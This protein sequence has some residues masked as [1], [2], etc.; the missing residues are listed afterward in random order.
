VLENFN[1]RA[2]L[3]MRREIAA[4]G[5]DIVLTISVENINVATWVAAWTLG[6]P[7]VHVIHSYFLMCW[8]STMF[9][10]NKTCERPCLQCRVASMGKKI[11]SHLVDGVAAEAAHSLSVH[12]EQGLFTRAAARVIPGAVKAPVSPPSFRDAQTGPLR[13]GYIGMLTPNKGVHTLAA[14]ATM[15]GN[16]APFEYLIAG[17]GKP[18]FVQEVLA[19]FPASKTS[20]FGWV[21]ANAFYPSID[22][23]VVPSVSA[24]CFGNVCVEALSFGVPVVV[25]RSGALPELVEHEKSGLIFKAGDHA[26]LADCL[27][28]IAG[29]RPLLKRMHHGALDRAKR[30]S[31]EAFATSFDTFLRQVRAGARKR[32]SQY[33]FATN[34]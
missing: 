3:R 32:K 28:Q 8:R 31:P 4:F 19:S 10:R 13:V 1:P 29:D 14:A 23:L 18:E 5:P 34:G 21:D 22:V 15:L 17:D 24:E 33:A 16:D 6:C 26:A 12:N 20:Y 7:T 9:A 30:F 2:L 25:A 11:C 27:R